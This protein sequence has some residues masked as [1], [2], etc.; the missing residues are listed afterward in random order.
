MPFRSLLLAAWVLA[1]F[2]LL[3]AGRAVKDT[4]F[5]QDVSVQFATSPDLQ[6]AEFR[7]LA[8][9]RDGIVHVLTDR[10]LARLF[11]NTLA[12]DRSFRPL[13]GLR[14]RDISLQ[15]G[16]LF[17]L[18]DDRFLANGWAGK[19]KAH[20]PDGQFQ[21]FAVSVTTSARRGDNG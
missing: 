5:L 7:K 19:V 18:Y 21:K 12:L 11:E 4:P 16:E 15:A 13:A 14:P 1:S 17:H 3:A 9:N 10:G 2:D 8:I 20:L 6:G